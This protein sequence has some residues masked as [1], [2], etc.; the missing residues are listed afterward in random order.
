MSTGR[1]QC[2]RSALVDKS[3]PALARRGDQSSRSMCSRASSPTL[4]A[5][6]VSLPIFHNPKRRG[7]AD[8]AALP[9]AAVVVEDR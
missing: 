4:A 6:E 2:L 5:H 9:R 1:R 3:R 8:M 7:L